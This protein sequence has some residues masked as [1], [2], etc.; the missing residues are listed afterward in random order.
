M[1]AV[2][3]GGQQ[4][5]S[6]SHLAAM[7]P[8][9]RRLLRAPGWLSVSPILATLWFSLRAL[10]LRIGR[11]QHPSITLSTQDGPRTMD[12]GAIATAGDRH[13]H[14]RPGWRLMA[15]Q[16]LPTGHSARSQLER[17]RGGGEGVLGDHAGR[18]EHLNDG[19][20]CSGVPPGPIEWKAA[21]RRVLVM[22]AAGIVPR[23][24]R[25]WQA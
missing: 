2:E 14:G 11:S 19:R 24:R 16:T 23:L 13:W 4:E 17:G 1:T 12:N 15:H 6:V 5:R 10:L 7:A 18:R 20:W 3:H 9:G 8:G 25:P 21:P 22:A